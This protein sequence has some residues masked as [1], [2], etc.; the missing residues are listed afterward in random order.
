M[1]PSA[2]FRGASAY[3]CTSN[4]PSGDEQ[5]FG[6]SRVFIDDV[7]MALG[8]GGRGEQKSHSLVLNVWCCKV[9]GG[10]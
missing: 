9:P 3:C 4:D 1:A 5:T 2:L 6:E 8:S 7:A 10:I